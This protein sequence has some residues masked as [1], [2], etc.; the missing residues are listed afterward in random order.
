MTSECISFGA[1]AHLKLRWTKCIHRV[2]ILTIT[3]SLIRMNIERWDYLNMWM[4]QLSVCHLNEWTSC[5]YN[6]DI[7]FAR[8]I[9][10]LDTTK[11]PAKPKRLFS[12]PPSIKSE[13]DYITQFIR[14]F[15][16]HDPYPQSVNTTCKW[17]P[18]QYTPS[19][20][21]KSINQIFQFF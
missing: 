21:V 2:K 17:S 8:R 11:P 7:Q 1:I 15:T 13:E 3:N 12:E 4:Y 16:T 9:R 19:F 18:W 10:H 5:L 14:I 6:K 20:T